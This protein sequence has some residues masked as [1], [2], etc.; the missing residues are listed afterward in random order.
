VVGHWAAAP[1]RK[2]GEESTLI[3]VGPEGGLTDEELAALTAAGAE[4]AGVSPHRLRSETAAVALV[5]AM[6]GGD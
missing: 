4:T 1:P 2:W 6:W 3:V 5:G